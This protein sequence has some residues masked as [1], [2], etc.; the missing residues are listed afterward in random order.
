MPVR[1][2][3]LGLG[4]I[5]AAIVRQL[6]SRPG[7]K[8]VSAVDI[9]PAKVGRDV[10]EVVGLDRRLGPRVVDDARRALAS[11][12]PDIVVLCTSS[13]LARVL[14]Q[15]ETVLKARVPIVS[16][17]E[18]LAYPSAPIAGLRPGWTSWRARRR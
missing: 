16:T 17:T 4:P 9:N 14:P 12:K 1:V 2:M 18:E 7:L 15:I 13:S 3:Q 6:T 11:S 5:G 10:G 8:V